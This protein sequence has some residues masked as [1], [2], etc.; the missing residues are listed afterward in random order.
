LLVDAQVPVRLAAGL[1][2]IG[3][4]VLHTFS[5]PDGNRSSDERIAALADQEGRVVV[6]KD[7][8]FRNSHLLTRFA[9]ASAGCRHGQHRQRRPVE[10]LRVADG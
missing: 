3:H 4:D 5:L 8:D 9:R 2:K 1:G 10:A 6:T 7:A